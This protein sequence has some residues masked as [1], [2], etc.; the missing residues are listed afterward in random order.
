MCLILMSSAWFF[1]S[2]ST[3]LI[4]TPIERM[5]FRVKQIAKDPLES[6]LDWGSPN[7]SDKKD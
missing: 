1:Q 5:L 7:S 6:Q 2:D 4:L 3:E